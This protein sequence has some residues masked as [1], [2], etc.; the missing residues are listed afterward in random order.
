MAEPCL[1]LISCMNQNSGAISA[2]STVVLVIVTGY[3]AYL[4]KKI[5][6]ATNQNARIALALKLYN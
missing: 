3:Y 4:T 5:L 1:D 2:I 6:E